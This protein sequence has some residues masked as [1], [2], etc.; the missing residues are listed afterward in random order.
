MD[1]GYKTCAFCG[2]RFDVF[3]HVTN[4]TFWGYRWGQTY[5]CSWKCLRAKE[6]EK[7][8]TKETGGPSEMAK[9]LTLEQKKKAVQIAIDGGNPANYLK[10]CGSDAPDKTWWFIKKKLKDTNPDLYAQIPDRRTKRTIKEPASTIGETTIKVRPD[11]IA[12]EPKT[13]ETIKAET[14]SQTMAMV[15][16]VI[17]KKVSVRIDKVSSGGITFT[18]IGDGSIIVEKIERGQAL[19]L[20]SDEVEKLIEALP[21]VMKMF[22]S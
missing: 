14:I 13:N 11:G 6:K 1:D 19:T 9:K 20:E 22:M 16:P 7:E 5:F 12:V 2:K 18:N 21:E 3:K 4:P 10:E 8:Q 17:H 15:E